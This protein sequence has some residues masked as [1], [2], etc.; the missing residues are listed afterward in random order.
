MKKGF[1]KDDTMINPPGQIMKNGDEPTDNLL[2]HATWN[3]PD[4][5]VMQ[6]TLIPY[7]EIS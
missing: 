2:H 3:I 6:I 1:K 7:L 5:R 4:K